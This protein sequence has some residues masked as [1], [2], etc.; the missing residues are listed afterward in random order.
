MSRFK[1]FI[2]S[3]GILVMAV[4]CLV[5]L[6]SYAAINCDQST[7]QSAINSAAAGATITCN[8]GTWTWTSGVSASGKALTIQGAGIDT[9]T[10]NV[11]FSGSAIALSG[12]STNVIRI[13]GFTFNQ[14]VAWN[15]G[16]ISADGAEAQ[17]GFRIDH[18]KFNISTAGPPSPR[19]I[20]VTHAYGLIDYNT[21]SVT[22]S[23][24]AQSI[25]VYGDADSNDGGFTSWQ[26]PLTLGTQNAV[27]IENNTF[28]YSNQLEDSIDAYGGARLVVRYNQFNNITLGFHGTD[29][30]NRRSTHSFE[31]Y[32]NKFTN[33]SGTQLRGLTV[34]GGTGVIHDNTYGG[35][36]SWYGITLMSYRSCPPL[37]QSTWGTCNGTA[38]EL[39]STN[40]SSDASRQSSTSGGVMFCSNARDTLCTSDANC[41]SGGRCTTYFDGAGSQ[42]YPCRDQPGVTTNQVSAPIYAWNNGSVGIGT[43]DGGYSCG[44]GISTIIASGRDFYN[45]TI[46]PGYI[47]YQYPHPLSSASGSGS[48]VSGALPSAPNNLTIQ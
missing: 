34:R 25:Q 46:M 29:S 32:N 18:N 20:V 31:I 36:T 45:N 30:G 5:P 17:V 27:Y 7:L 43:Y 33:N 11:N 1:I 48:I 19:G 2:L 26:R 35:S 9:T 41:S 24:S 38:W 47:P 37:D 40:L 23:G 16:V 21:F 44:T 22:S 12:S 42:G 39:G 3:I 8:A 28:T 13:T 15:Y 10:I 4:F 6:N 14:L